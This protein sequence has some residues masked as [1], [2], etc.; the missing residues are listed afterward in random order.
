MIGVF[1][2]AI[3]TA[4][5]LYA[6]RHAL[7]RVGKSMPLWI[8]PAGT[9]AAMLIYSVWADYTW[10]NRAM[11][12]LPT[13]A[14]VLAE[15]RAPSPIAP[16]TYVAPPIV[17][18]AAL[19]ESKITEQPDGIRRAEIILIERRKPAI[20]VPQEFHCVQRSARVAGG[21]WGTT[22]DEDP[23]YRQVCRT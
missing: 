9:G 7:H 19:D 10:A 20:I 5:A 3:F 17:R 15:G 21:E 4:A 18:I 1:A 2:V 11:R 14:V 23:I 8:L 12:Q 6:L 13:G 16:W 22:S